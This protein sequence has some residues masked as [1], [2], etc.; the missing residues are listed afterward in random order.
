MVRRAFRP[1]VGGALCD[2]A[3]MP[4]PTKPMQ[5]AYAF[6]KPAHSRMLNFR[7]TANQA[8]GPNAIGKSPR[9]KARLT[10]DK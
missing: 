4:T 8:I 10:R 1:S 7:K 3:I 2:A 9:A 6:S 5:N